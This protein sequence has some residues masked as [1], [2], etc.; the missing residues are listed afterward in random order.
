MKIR[1]S[2]SAV[3]ENVPYIQARFQYLNLSIEQASRI[4]EHEKTIFLSSDPTLVY[5]TEFEQFDYG[6]YAFNEILSPEQF[7]LYRTHMDECIA[8]YENNL[9]KDDQSAYHLA[10]VD[11]SNELLHYYRNIFLPDFFKEDFYPI[12]SIRTENPK[13][14]FLKEQYNCFQKREKIKLIAIHFRNHKTFC[15]NQLKTAL[16]NHELLCLWPNYAHFKQELDRPTLSVAEAIETD[17]GFSTN[18]E[19][20]LFLDSKFSALNTFYRAMNNKYHPDIAVDYED[21]AGLLKVDEA[22]TLR[23]RLMCI[24]LLEEGGYKD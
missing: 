12:V 10:K 7:E 23:Y 21:D 15:P 9:A 4:Y 6:F 18:K 20:R 14:R 22:E 16:F 17:I 13:R 11:Y 5:L 1:K 3:E 24:I 19:L 8:V 2:I